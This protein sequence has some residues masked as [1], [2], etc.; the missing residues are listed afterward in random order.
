MVVNGILTAIGLWFLGIPM[1][2]SLAL[3]AGVLNFI[4]NFGPLIA[5]IPA[6]L[7]ALTI[8]P[9]AALFVGLLYIVVQSVDGYVF[10]PL[11]NRRSVE[12]PPALTIS[13]QVILGV[14]VGGMG[15]VLA[16]PLTA[17]LIVIVRM[18]YVE[19]TLGKENRMLNEDDV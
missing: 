6:V 4:P 16:G 7:I 10:T 18:L 2:L 13:A 17:M 1:A 5:G 8:S 9:Q 19:D 15:V 12:L 11:V 3:L 14:L